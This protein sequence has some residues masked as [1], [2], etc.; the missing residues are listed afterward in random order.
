MTKAN[1]RDLLA[2]ARSVVDR[3]GTNEEV[4]AYVGWTRRSEVKVY[5]GQVESATAAETMGVGVRVM[6]DGR[7]G[8]AYAGSLDPEVVADTLVQARDNAS[9]AAIDRD[10]AFVEPDRVEPVEMDHW[11]EAVLEMS[12]DAKFAMAADLERQ[13]RA[14]DPRISG[15]RSAAYADSAGEMA[16]ASTTGI[17]VSDRGTGCSVSVSTMAEADGQTQ[18]GWG[19]DL[20]RD[21]DLLDVDKAAADAA[22]R[23]TRLLGATQPKSTTTTVVFEPRQAAS[24][25]GVV[26]GMLSGTRVAKGRSPFGNFLGEDI[27]SPLFSL[28]DDP[29]DQRSYGADRYDGEGLASRPTPLVSE[30]RLDGFVYD[31]WSASRL[32]GRS[33]ASA[34]RS[35]RSTP[36]A[37]PR[38]LIMAPGGQSLDELIADVDDGILVLSMSGLHSGVNAISGD[39]SVGIDGLRIRNGALAEPLREAT[40]AS[41]VQRLLTNIRA[42]GSELEWQP[43]GT[44]ACALSIGDVSLSGS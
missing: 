21:P 18:T 41:T 5:E 14:A 33:T 20:G 25:A 39:F 44:G 1:S 11:N 43:S 32:L 35:Y 36:S 12:A 28:L 13:V 7:P 26:G 16:L 6:A 38:V 30:G 27:A 42:V 2:V 23:A 24:L 37:S 9:F 31:S 40:I 17:S 8:F 19:F 10:N 3:A 34:V 22:E 15:I 4:E 29:T